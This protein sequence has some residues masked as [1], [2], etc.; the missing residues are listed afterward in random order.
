MFD[1]LYKAE[2][3]IETRSREFLHIYFST[4]DALNKSDN[5]EF[6]PYCLKT[7]DTNISTY[8]TEN[9]IEYFPKK[10]EYNVTITCTEVGDSWED[11]EEETHSIRDIPMDLYIN[12]SK[13]DIIEYTTKLFEDEINRKM[14]MEVRDKYSP[15][16]YMDPDLVIAIANK[17]K[18]Y[19]RISYKEV[20]E[21]LKHV[22]LIDDNEKVK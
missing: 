20:S 1:D 16:M 9:V 19:D 13:E 6:Y 12:G 18:E 5:L 8:R 4:I 10:V 17:V 14:F 22:N 11:F 2:D 21:I 7:R 3:K 15:I